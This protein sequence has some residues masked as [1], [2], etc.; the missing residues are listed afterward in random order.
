MENGDFARAVGLELDLVARGMGVRLRRF[1][2][3]VE[4]GVI[5][6]LNVEAPGELDVSTAETML[7]LL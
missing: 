4:D 2:M 6:A 7:E 3:I 5:S 1:A